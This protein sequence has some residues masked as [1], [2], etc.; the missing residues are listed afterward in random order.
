MIQGTQLIPANELPAV[1]RIA[2]TYHKPIFGRV[3]SRGE[4]V[5]IKICDDVIRL[6]P[7]QRVAVCTE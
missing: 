4:R 6:N 5:V 2:S 1:F 3:V 7:G